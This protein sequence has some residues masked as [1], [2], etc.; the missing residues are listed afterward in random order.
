MKK[1]AII[2]S[3]CG[4]QDGAEITEAVSTL[5]AL[6]DLGAEYQVFAPSQEFKANNFL[7]GQPSGE[8][9]N[10]MQESARIARGNVKDLNELKTSD[11]D[12]LAIPG[13][14]GVALHLCDWAK[15]GSKSTVQPQVQKIIEGFYADQKP[16]L[17]ICIA[18]ALIAKVLGKH[19]VTL[20]LGSDK[21]N[22]AEL[23][24]TGAIHENCR[25]DDYVTD[26]EHK[27]ITTPAYMYDDAK[28]FE[29]FRGINA[30]VKEFFEMA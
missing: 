16:I 17:A 3:G 24:K 19:G 6:S 7:T 27:I 18:P 2:L 1:I 28:P 29:V 14:F 13:G 4:N 5:I 25:V 12:G 30:A 9:R 26:R 15:K 8:T 11:F 10:I 22:A 23:E 21:E 20:T